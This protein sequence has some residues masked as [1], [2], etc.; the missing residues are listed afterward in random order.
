MKSTLLATAAIC[1]WASFCRAQIIYNGDFET[2]TLSGW[3]TF[4]TPNGSLEPSRLSLPAVTLFDVLDNGAPSDAPQF[5]VGEVNLDLTEQGGG[6]YQTF[7]VSAGQYIISADFAAYDSDAAFG[8]TEAGVETVF[9]DSVTVGTLD[10][11][12]IYARQTERGIVRGT[13]GL[14]GGTHQITIE[15]TRPNLNIPGGLGTTPFEYVDNVVV[16][17]VPE[18][19]IMGVG[20]L[21]LP[22]L[23]FRVFIRKGRLPHAVGGNCCERTIV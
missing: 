2:G 12:Q 19:S 10:F 16:T 13:L 18:P 20:M 7:N 21:G 17:P 3:T 5:Q 14:S 15:F 1:A 22:T 6:I 9:V 8:N 4:T 11:G 23:L